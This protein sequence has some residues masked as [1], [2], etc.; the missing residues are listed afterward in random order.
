MRCTIHTGTAEVCALVLHFAQ[1][2]ATQLAKGLRR[3]H[4]VHTPRLAAFSGR[5][6]NTA[7]PDQ[8]SGNRICARISKMRSKSLRLR[9][10]TTSCAPRTVAV[11]VCELGKLGFQQKQQRRL[12]KNPPPSRSSITS[13][14]DACLLFSSTAPCCH[15]RSFARKSS[16]RSSSCRQRRGSLRS[17]RQA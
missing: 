16:A 10:N 17:N 5:R 15:T 6:P 12:L 1:D 14:A 13:L 2:S 9:V 3:D 11:T 7:A 4:G 8:D